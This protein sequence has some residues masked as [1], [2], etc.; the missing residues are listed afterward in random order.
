[1]ANSGDLS[2]PAG[3]KLWAHAP[4]HQR[5]G[6]HE[7]GNERYLIELD[8]LEVGET[9]DTMVKP[10]HVVQGEY[11]DVPCI[12]GG[13]S[14][15]I[16]GTI[17]LQLPELEAVVCNKTF[18]DEA[19]ITLGIDALDQQLIDSELKQAVNLQWFIGVERIEGPKFAICD[20]MA[21]IKIQLRNYS[22]KVYGTD[23]VNGDLHVAID[24]L[25]SDSIAID[26]QATKSF[27]IRR[28]NPH[29]LHEIVANLSVLPSAWDH[30][31]STATIEFDL[32]YK[33]R[34]IARNSMQLKVTP[35]FATEIMTDVVLV[36]TERY[37]IPDFAFFL[38]FEFFPSMS[39]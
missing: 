19:V 1:V 20:R 30:L 33:D 36:V 18:F 3:L 23:T 31:L 6:N 4:I 8:L 26:G 25:N 35:P 2:I 38:K 14:R 5:G 28:I 34:V 24:C 21:Q 37:L 11:I 9:D 7:P 39:S 29:E 13:E 15:R 22:K 17:K 27:D 32:F 10:L 16:P 12:E